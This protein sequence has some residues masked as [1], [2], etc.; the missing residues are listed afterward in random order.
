MIEEGYQSAETLR[1]RIDAC[2]EWLDEPRAHR[3]GRP[4]RIQGRPGD[5][6]GR[7]QG[8][9]SWP[10][11]TTPTTSASSRPSPANAIDEVF[12]GSCMTNIGH[13]RAAGRILDK[14]RAWPRPRSGSRRRPRWTRPSS[15]AKA[16]TRS[17]IGF[18]GPDRDARLLAVHGQPGPGRRRDDGH[19]HLDPEFRPPAGR[20]HPRLSRL[21]GAG[22]PGRA[23]GAAS[24]RSRST[25]PS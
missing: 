20:Q 7:D 5:R 22:R 4:R 19:F 8:A 14:A 6:P 15:C 12:I 1:R 13:F 9:A 16:I 2:R 3:A 11:P 21:V 25:W 23:Q 18:G 17:S 24:L 10:V